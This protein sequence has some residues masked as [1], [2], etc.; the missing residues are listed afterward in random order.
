MYLQCFT[1]TIRKI[2]NYDSYA[3]K[4]YYCVYF[5]INLIFYK[6]LIMFWLLQVKRKDGIAYFT[7]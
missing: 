5:V 6:G 2:I 1:S 7:L 4:A 3:K